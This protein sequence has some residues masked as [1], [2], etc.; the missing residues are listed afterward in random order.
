[1]RAACIGITLSHSHSLTAFQSFNNRSYQSY[2]YLTATI[3]SH[4]QLPTDYFTIFKFLME[5][6]KTPFKVLFVILLCFETQVHSTPTLHTV[7]DELLH[8]ICFKMPVSSATMIPTVWD[9]LLH[10]IRLEMPVHSASML[11][12]VWD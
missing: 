3:E 1:M 11:P 7:F 12:A 8:H 5:L 2:V 6:Q 10:P 4:L 9:E